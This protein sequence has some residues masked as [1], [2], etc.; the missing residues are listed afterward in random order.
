VEIPLITRSSVR[1]ARITAL[2]LLAL[3][4]VVQCR[5]QA[6][7]THLDRFSAV[8]AAHPIKLDASLADPVWS[9]APTTG[10]NGFFDITRRST[11]TFRTVAYLLYDAQNLYVGFRCD[12]S[13]V[14]VTAT[15]TA[16]DIGFGIDDFVGVGIDTTT[17]GSQVYYFEETPRGVRY[18]QSSE[19]ARFRPEWWA[20]AQLV[21]GGWNAEMIIPLSAI[22]TP[23]ANVQTWRVNFVRNISAR[24]EHYSWAY[25]GLMQDA[26][27]PQWPNTSDARFWP[28]MN[29]LNFSGHS[30]RPRPR[31]RADFYGLQTA[32]A[33]RQSFAQADGSFRQE[34]PRSVGIDFSL[35]LTNTAS[36][37]GT[38][39]PDFSN[40]E[41]DQRSIAPQEFR[42][43]LSEYRP[44][45][46]QG[47]GFINP[48]TSPSAGFWTPNNAIF[49]SPAVGPFDR[50]TKIEGTAGKQSFGILN[51][52]G[53][54]QTTSNEF[55]DTAY[56]FK[57]D[58]G[59][60]VFTYWSDGVFAHHSIGGDDLTAEFGM[61][62]QNPRNGVS[63]G[64]DGAVEQRRSPSD[65]FSAS[66]VNVY[67]GVNQSNWATGVRFQN[68]T[69]MYDPAD[70]FTIAS[71]VRGIAAF[72]TTSGNLRGI[73]N[74]TIVVGG[75]RFVDLT[76]APHETDAGLQINATL[77][78]QWSINSL[79]PIIGSLRGYSP[80]DP[81]PA[82]CGD[83]SL[84][85]TYFTGFPKYLC[86][87]N[88]RFN[89]YGGGIG[90][91]D[92]TPNPADVNYSAGPFGAYFVHQ[93]AASTSRQL[94]G[95]LS[96]SL[97]Y[98]G[99]TA[100]TLADGAAQSQWL[101]RISL[102][103]SLGSDSNAAVSLRSINGFVNGLTASPGLNLAASYHR[104]FPN[105]N[106][107]FVSFGTPAA[108]QTLDRFVLKY[109]VHLGAG[110]GT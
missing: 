29:G 87:R 3:Q 31:S 11:A 43:I 37:V 103:E 69:P 72:A 14:A 12:Q 50:G 51:F 84:A 108:P 4:L 23:A 98:D 75:D 42:R 95:R 109:V 1:I 40:V 96:V 107:L 13:G 92:G 36:F 97:E 68:I 81:G 39:N 35:P 27:V 17:N 100:R 32:G 25:E 57:H 24:T 41:I 10:D 105:E 94:R 80:N 102:G 73:K 71:D 88:D 45:F 8:P 66:S 78:N 90:H 74:Y 33:D 106:E 48:N 34:T 99:T 89:T 59:H 60:S 83:P 56:G 63:L 93:F 62:G 19:N 28:E 110:A 6:A 55:D 21:P 30:V 79:G 85:R 82:G 7:V 20:A 2:G 38:V 54:D 53:F 16:N 86:G 22:R 47:A 5:A 49:Y 65:A 9:A 101:R 61:S 58:V 64:G 18:Q 70:G 44:F 77:E 104:K 15:Q 52:R 26:V 76:G 67:A 46:S 91:G